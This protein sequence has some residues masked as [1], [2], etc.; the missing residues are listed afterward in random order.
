MVKKPFKLINASAIKAGMVINIKRGKYNDI[1][2]ILAKK[3]F[4]NVE[5]THL[6][7][8][9]A[10]GSA[11]VGSIKG[12]EKVKVITGA[13]RKYVIKQIRADV[14]KYLFDVEH[15]IDTLNLIEDMELCHKP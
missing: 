9:D 2:L 10:Y 6:S 3:G 13:K 8:D 7:L 12:T 15:L 14:F 4:T 1:A 5:Y 11:M